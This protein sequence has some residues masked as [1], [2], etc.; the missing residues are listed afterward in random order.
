LAGIYAAKRMLGEPTTPLFSITDF[1]SLEPNQVRS[2]DASATS[3]RIST[4]LGLSAL[5]NTLLL[6]MPADA[7]L[8][9]HHQTA[10]PT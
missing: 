6:V 1:I 3:W 7:R 10:E 5:R 9:I 4:S 8:H 2:F